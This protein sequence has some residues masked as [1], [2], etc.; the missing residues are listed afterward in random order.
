MITRTHV[1]SA[2]E[3]VSDIVLIGEHPQGK[4]DSFS[5]I[6]E[7]IRQ[8]P[9]SDAEVRDEIRELLRHTDFVM[10]G[11]GDGVWG[12]RNGLGDSRIDGETPAVHTPKQL[13]DHL[14]ELVRRVDPTIESE[15]AAHEATKEKLAEAQARIAELE[16]PAGDQRTN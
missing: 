8:Q 5:A 9:E 4:R 7:Y 1:E 14:R 10:F 6:V 2:I 16:S 3:D 12:L 13:R 11:V 15:Q